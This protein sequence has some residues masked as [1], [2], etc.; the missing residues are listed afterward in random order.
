MKYAILLNER[1][2]DYSKKEYLLNSVGQT[3]HKPYPYQLKTAR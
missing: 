2:W 3:R 1:Y